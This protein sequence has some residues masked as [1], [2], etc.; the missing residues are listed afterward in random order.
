[1][2]RPET[3]RI[4]DF[5]AKAERPRCNPGPLRSAGPDMRFFEKLSGQPWGSLAQKAPV[6]L[7]VSVP[8]GA[9]GCKRGTTRGGW[10]SDR[11]SWAKPKGEGLYRSDPGQSVAAALAERADTGPGPGAGPVPPPHPSDPS[12][13]GMVARRFARDQ[14]RLGAS[15]RR[16]ALSPA[17]MAVLTTSFPTPN[18]S[19]HR[20]SP[21]PGLDRKGSQTGSPFRSCDSVPQPRDRS[22]R[23]GA[24][25]LPMGFSIL[26]GN[27]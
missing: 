26:A 18:P 21:S 19:P 11:S 25:V 20:A 17:T 24:R 6:R 2:V 5:I 16:G 13:G 23:A 14:R 12:P 22:A 27:P 3:L 4:A 8:T 1:M 15:L 7:P 9:A 10:G